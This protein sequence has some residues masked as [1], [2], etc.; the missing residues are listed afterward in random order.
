MAGR[1]KE[2]GQAKADR[3]P[4][5]PWAPLAREDPGPKVTPSDPRPQ[6][7]MRGDP[8]RHTAPQLDRPQ[9]V[10]AEGTLSVEAVAL[11]ARH[12]GRLGALQEETPAPSTAALE[13]RAK[14]SDQ[15]VAPVGPPHGERRRL[16]HRPVEPVEPV[17][18]GVDRVHPVERAGEV[19]PLEASGREA[20][21]PG[22]PSA[23]RRLDRLE[24]LS[25][26]AL[27][28]PARGGERSSES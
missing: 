3:M 10:E 27:E 7:R 28:V 6:P 17:E 8:V 12:L 25:A 18:P 26:A 16:G 20:E 24:V 19:Q 11:E 23:D 1:R 21:S 13:A 14:A 15:E 4:V 5:P 2:D 22:T 9:L